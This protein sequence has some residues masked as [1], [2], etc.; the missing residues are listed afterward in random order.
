MEGRE[1]RRKEGRK[2]MAENYPNLV[3]K[4]NLQIQEV[5]QNLG[6]GGSHL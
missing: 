1:G 4:I 5:K 3:K 6:T 2:E